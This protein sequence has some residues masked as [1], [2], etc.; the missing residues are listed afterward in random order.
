MPIASDNLFGII[1]Q[2][3]SFVTNDASHHKALE[4]VISVSFNATYTH[5]IRLLLTVILCIVS[6]LI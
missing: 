2:F 5:A 6:D 3:K 4:N 1:L